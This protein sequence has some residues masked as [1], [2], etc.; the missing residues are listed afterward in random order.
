MIPNPRFQKDYLFLLKDM[1]EEIKQGIPIFQG[2]IDAFDNIFFEKFKKII[3][4]T[5][6]EVDENQLKELIAEMKTDTQKLH[7]YFNTILKIL[8]DT[9]HFE[10]SDFEKIKLYSCVSYELIFQGNHIYYMF[11][12]ALSLLQHKK[13]NTFFEFYITDPEEKAKIFEN[14]Q[15]LPLEILENKEFKLTFELS[16]NLETCVSPFSKWILMEA[17]GEIVRET[18]YNEMVT[19][20]GYSKYEQCTDNSI[21]LFKVWLLYNENASVPLHLEFIDLFLV[22][23]PLFINNTSAPIIDPIMAAYNSIAS[24]I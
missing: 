22:N 20:L 11:T 1:V 17:I 8:Y 7:R 12:R 24:P 6:F 18:F 19:T 5:E 15:N 4:L 9:V 14:E 13:L 3:F 10:F 16:K 21:L 2:I 23:N